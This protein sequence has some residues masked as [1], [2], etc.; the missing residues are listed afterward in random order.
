MN[1]DLQTPMTTILGGAIDQLTDYLMDNTD[2]G[3][4][5]IP[6]V[7]GARAALQSLDLL[8]QEAETRINSLLEEI[9]SKFVDGGEL[10]C[11]KLD[12]SQA[13]EGAVV[14]T[15][16]SLQTASLKSL[17]VKAAKY[18]DEL[19]KLNAPVF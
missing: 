6:D 7:D 19:V 18:R 5:E 11:M 13:V 15:G 10:G 16:L 2:N 12:A 1:T 17:L 9:Q 8:L 3:F 14:W 4:E